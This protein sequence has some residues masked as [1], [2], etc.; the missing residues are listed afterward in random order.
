MNEKLD[1]LD[2]AFDSLKSQRAVLSDDFSL[3]LEERLMKA[4][5]VRK[6]KRT[7][8]LAL[9]AGAFCLLM[10]GAGAGYAATDGFTSWPWSIFIQ[11]DGTVTNSDGETIG[12]MVE[13]EDGSFTAT[14]E[15]GEG[16]I[17]TIDQLGSGN[18]VD[19]IQDGFE[20]TSTIL[21]HGLVNTASVTQTS[22]DNTSAVNQT[23]NNNTASVTQ[24]G[25]I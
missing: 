7:V 24:G 6:S 11:E 18:N 15:T 23:G 21:Q 20:N 16:N 4:S 8:W 13:N 25:G 3:N 10:T 9:A 2:L 17:S 5:E 14:V 19:L 22:S 1:N 12:G